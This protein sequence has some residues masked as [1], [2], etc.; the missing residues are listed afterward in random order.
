MSEFLI[1]SGSE[2]PLRQP[3]PATGTM[4]AQQVLNWLAFGR[5][6]DIDLTLRPYIT[7]RWVFA[8]QSGRESTEMLIALRMRAAGKTAWPE[9]EPPH[10][11]IRSQRFQGRV[12]E[13][14]ARA[15]ELIAEEGAPAASLALMLAQELATYHRQMQHLYHAERT[16][17]DALATGELT[18]RAV[19]QAE[20][21]FARLPATIVPA[22]VFG[23]PGIWMSQEGAI[24]LFD[25]HLYSN[26]YLLTAEV[27]KVWVTAEAEAAAPAEPMKPRAGI[28][29]KRA[30]DWDAFAA[31]M[32]RVAALAGGDMTAAQF[33]QRM[34]DWVS[35]QMPDADPATVDRY[36]KAYLPS[37]TFPD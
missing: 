35:E 3:L 34:R 1:P 5:G 12:D 6:E 9:D 13:I 22:E 7:R 33:K 17:I 19:P 18:A 16:L 32:V 36:F 30:H 31:E 10:P 2:S 15:D 4:T 28:G 37:G 29:G 21:R 26:S 20:E 27:R 24:H 14:L 8:P 11:D 25:V 23:T